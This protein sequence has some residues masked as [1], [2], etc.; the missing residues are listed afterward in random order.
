MTVQDYLKFE[1]DVVLEKSKLYK[2]K[3][4]RW[5]TLMKL[6]VIYGNNIEEILN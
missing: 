3:A 5:Q 6:A 2:A 1:D 4:E